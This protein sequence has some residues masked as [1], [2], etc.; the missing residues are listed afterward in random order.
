MSVVNKYC[1]F[2]VCRWYGTLVGLFFSYE[3]TPLIPRSGFSVGTPIFLPANST[4]ATAE[5]IVNSQSNL[6]NYKL[7]PEPCRSNILRLLC[8]T[9]LRPCATDG[10][11]KRRRSTKDLE[12]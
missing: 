6:I 8:S 12:I 4:L 1:L 5:H 9:W 11:G 2:F 3:L 7:I 10:N